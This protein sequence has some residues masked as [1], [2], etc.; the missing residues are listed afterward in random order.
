MQ[1]SRLLSALALIAMACQGTQVEPYTEVVMSPGMRVRGTNANGSVTVTAGEG[2]WRTYEGD[3]FRKRIALIPRDQRWNGSLGLYD[4]G[5]PDGSGGQL[6]LEEGRLHFESVDAA[7]R[8]LNVG[9]AQL[10]PV[11]NNDGLVFCYGKAS[12]GPDQPPEVRTVKIWQIYVDGF[13]PESIPGA[14]DEA[15]EISG[16]S[17]PE[18]STPNERAVGYEMV[19][20]KEPYR[21]DPSSRPT[22]NEA[23]DEAAG[24]TTRPSTAH[25]ATVYFP[26]A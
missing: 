11:Y 22:S 5:A 19:F 21:P 4:P 25:I 10:K 8:W 17:P 6:I 3:G 7:L 14:M 23:S 1:H 18:K 26:D 12:R 13:K 16:G 20:S 15:I 2:A 24:A 9:S